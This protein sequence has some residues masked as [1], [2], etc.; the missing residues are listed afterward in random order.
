MKKE[1]LKIS[2]KNYETV[3][4]FKIEG[5]MGDVLVP[6]PPPPPVPFPPIGP[7][8]DGPTY[9]DGSGGGPNPLGTLPTIHPYYGARPWR[10]LVY[11]YVKSCQF[12]EWLPTYDWAGGEYAK[13]WF[14][15]WKERSGCVNVGFSPPDEKVEEVILGFYPTDE[16]IPSSVGHYVYIASYSASGTCIEIVNEGKYGLPFEQQTLTMWARGE[17]FELVFTGETIFT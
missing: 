11:R 8:P 3:F 6:T 9:P 1:R 15:N 12:N 17:L 10:Q 7:L 4:S 16:T 5:T 2:K 13:W 14:E